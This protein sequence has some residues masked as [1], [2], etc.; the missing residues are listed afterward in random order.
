MVG[1]QDIG[2]K[3]KA[4]TKWGKGGCGQWKPIQGQSSAEGQA[5]TMTSLYN[6]RNPGI[7]GNI[8]EEKHEHKNI[9]CYTG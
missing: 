2:I 6:T 5:T 8:W 4:I 3:G 1:V 9:N 7:P